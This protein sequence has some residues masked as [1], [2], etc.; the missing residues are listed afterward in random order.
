MHALIANCARCSHRVSTWIRTTSASCTG[1]DCTEVSPGGLPS[2]HR[3]SALTNPRPKN[4]GFFLPDRRGFPAHVTIIGVP[5]KG[6]ADARVV[7]Y[8][9]GGRSA[10]P[11]G[12]RLQRP[13]VEGRRG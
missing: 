5:G 6:E 9:N 13:A 12:L 8:L 7:C 3:R 10:G 1:L 4:L 2:L 11:I